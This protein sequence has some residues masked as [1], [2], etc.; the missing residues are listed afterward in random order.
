MALHTPAQEAQTWRA[1]SWLERAFVCLP[2]AS[3]GQQPWAY[4]RGRTQK[5]KPLEPLS[6]GVWHPPHSPRLCMQ[7]HSTGSPPAH[8]DHPPGVWTS[9]SY[10]GGDQGGRERG[11]DLR[12]EACSRAFALKRPYIPKKG[13]GTGTSGKE[14]AQSSAVLGGKQ[15]WA[16]WSQAAKQLTREAN[17]LQLPRASVSASPTALAAEAGTRER[18][19]QTHHCT[20]A[21][22]PTHNTISFAPGKAGA[23]TARP[24]S[25]A[26]PGPSIRVGAKFTATRQDCK[27]GG[28]AAGELG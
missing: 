4:K 16:A 26:H 22:H 12:R 7:A 9:P 8:C 5:N 24:P 2:E 28:G 10:R 11:P 17:Q 27:H 25:E 18:K 14:L 19:P 23:V 3:L 15:P 13:K 6:S 20:T 21:S 1:L